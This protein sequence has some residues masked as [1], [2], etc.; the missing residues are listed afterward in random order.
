MLEATEGG[1]GRGRMLGKGDVS[2]V[3]MLEEDNDLCKTFG[4]LIKTDLKF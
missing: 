3:S 2:D 1:Q 4:E